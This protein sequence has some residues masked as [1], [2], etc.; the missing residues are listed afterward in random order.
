MASESSKTPSDGEHHMRDGRRSSGGDAADAEQ[1]REPWQAADLHP[2]AAHLR[3]Q[4]EVRGP[5]DQGDDAV[6]SG[7]GGRRCGQRGGELVRPT[8]Y[9]SSY[10]I[11]PPP[12]PRTAQL[13]FLW[14]RCTRTTPPQP[15]GCRRNTFLYHPVRRHR[16]G[17]QSRPVWYRHGVER[18]LPMTPIRSRSS[19]FSRL[20]HRASGARAHGGLRSCWV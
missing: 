15:G 16:Q 13:P 6:G 8:G 19:R 11:R 12:V 18:S 2:R 5:Q 3:P 9:R 1:P 7:E 20:R 10:R 14:S 4:A 17:L